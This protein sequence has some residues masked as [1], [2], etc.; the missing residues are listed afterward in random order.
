MST[1]S[2]IVSGL[3][4]S[5]EGGT[6]SGDVL[7]K[8]TGSLLSLVGLLSSSDTSPPETGDDNGSLT[9][10]SRCAPTFIHLSMHNDREIRGDKKRSRPAA[11]A[12]ELIHND[13]RTRCILRNQ[14]QYSRSGS[15]H[16]AVRVVIF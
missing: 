8:S 4:H 16:H 14:T 10:K 15:L 11:R 9:P 1:A 5:G 13:Y 2:V 12:R 3:F 6:G 7:N